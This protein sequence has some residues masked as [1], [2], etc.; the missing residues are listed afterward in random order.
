MK[1]LYEKEN[2]IVEQ[3]VQKQRELGKLCIQHG[4]DKKDIFFLRTIK[5]SKK[6]ALID[7]ILGHNVRLDD[8]HRATML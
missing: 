5:N 6:Q 1:D 4:I 2:K 3:N 8:L 7:Y